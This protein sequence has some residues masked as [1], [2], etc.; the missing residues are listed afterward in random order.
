MATKDKIGKKKAGVHKIGITS[1]IL[2]MS[3]S[4]LLVALTVSQLI[5]RNISSEKLVNNAKDNLETLAISKGE[6]LEEYILAQK[7]L[8]NSVTSNGD[9]IEACQKY[10]KT[11]VIDTQL[12]SSIASYLKQIQTDSSNLYENFFITVGA[13]GFADCIENSTL[14]DVSEE[15]F[16]EECVENGY[17]FGNNVSPVTGNPVYVIAYAIKDPST[18]KVIGTV[19]NSIDLATMTN[20]LITDEYYDIKLLDLNGIVIASPDAEAILTLDLNQLD[21]E[22]WA[23]ILNTERG[24]TEFTDPYT[25]KLGYTG[26]CVTENFV[27]E[28]SVDDS[29]FDGARESL[30]IAAVIITV[31]AAIIAIILITLA[32]LTIVKPLRKASA[33]LNKLVADIN[34]GN[35]DLTT[36][37]KVSSG[38]EAGQIS[39][40]INQFIDTLQ[41]VMKMMGDSSD[42]LGLISATVKDNIAATEDQISNVSSTM[43]EMSA[44][45]EETSA[46]L[47]QVVDEIETVSKLID[48]VYNDAESRSNDLQQIVVKVDSMRNNAMQERDES[49]EQTN[50][51][52][53]TL[54][55]S[56]EA[57]K[58][59]DKITSLTEE[60][61]SISSQ[62]NLLALNA[63]IEA[64]RAGEA[65]RGF[66]VVAGEISKLADNSRETANNIQAISNG[67]IASVNDLSEKAEQ[68]ARTLMDVN[69]SGRETVENLTGAYQDDIKEMAQS[70]DKFAESSSEVQIAV[71]NIKESIDAINISVEEIA[72]GVTNVTTATV[73]IAGNMA[74][75]TTESKENLDISSKLQEEVSKFS[76]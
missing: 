15:P 22:S 6:S 19:N 64:A 16:Y 73:D 65:G 72:M 39:N 43:Q 62:T 9:V 71:G 47:T 10:A 45:S 5:A 26:F 63:S 17:F 40:S 68:I 42:K 59:V 66:A 52:I 31:I 4:C 37:I 49:D 46:S 36:R 35:G 56:M 60:I 67:V 20:Q 21:P 74:N 38:D 11:G 51:A 30:T 69:Q 57:A 12:Q 34:S 18:G 29:A 53:E 13:T 7:T 58:E 55:V 25:S 61:L 27:T 1:K 8:T 44:S 14:H 76:Y 28:V 2:I 50:E 54:H 3:I 41:E 75:I 32:S 23:Y 33:T 24:V 70:M 48:S